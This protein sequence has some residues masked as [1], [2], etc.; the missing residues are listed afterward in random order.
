MAELRF[1]VLGFAYQEGIKRLAEGFIS[2]GAALHDAV[3]KATAALDAY[4]SDVAAGGQRIGEWEDGVCLWEQ[5]DL[6]QMRIEDAQDVRKAFALAAYHHWERWARRWTRS[7]H[8][9]HD[10]L[11]AQTLQQGY[12]IDP[13]I[14]ALRDL[15]N[16]L[17]HNN[18]V[19]GD[20]LTR[21]WP[22]VVTSYRAGVDMDLYEEIELSD[23]QVTA[24]FD[25]IA[26][27]GPTA[28]MLPSPST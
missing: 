19:W 10:R 7:T 1:N 2:A 27:S 18:P 28:D 8:N 6:L 22:E 24:I 5:S 12:A 26:N 21:S 11:T 4:E 14:N 13:R 23:V 15:V 17:K 9:K 25:V 16:A 20:A 3:A